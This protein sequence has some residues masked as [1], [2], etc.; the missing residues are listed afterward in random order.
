MQL[1]VY[2]EYFTITNMNGKTVWYHAEK[3][4]ITKLKDMFKAAYQKQ[5]AEQAAEKAK[6]IDGNASAEESTS[7][8]DAS[9]SHRTQMESEGASEDK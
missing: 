5:K 2:D 6:E 3:E 8:P 4:A 9:N 1:S 7:E